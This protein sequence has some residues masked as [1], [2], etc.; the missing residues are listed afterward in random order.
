[1]KSLVFS[2]EQKESAAYSAGYSSTGEVPEDAGGEEFLQ[3][4]YTDILINKFH[5]L[6]GVP[7]Q[8]DQEKP[9]RHGRFCC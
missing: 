8:Q 5:I 7:H 1:M 4:Y 9:L 6:G 2:W 3:N